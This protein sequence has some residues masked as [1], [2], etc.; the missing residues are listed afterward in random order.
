MDSVHL[1]R[2]SFKEIQ[3]HI[4]LVTTSTILSPVASFSVRPAGESWI[5]L[6]NQ[7]RVSIVLTNGRRALPGVEEVGHVEAVQRVVGVRAILDLGQEKV[8]R[9]PGL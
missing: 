7:R 2:R 4:Q 6:T 5:K 3:F 8:V 1:W 9:S